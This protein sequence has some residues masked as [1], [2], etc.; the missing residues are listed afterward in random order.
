MKGRQ[1]C[2]DVVMVEQLSQADA[3]QQGQLARWDLENVQT[4]WSSSPTLR[5]L[6]AVLVRL[7]FVDVSLIREDNR[8]RY[9]Q[10]QR[11]TFHLPTS[12]HDLTVT[13]TSIL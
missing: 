7:P 12:H 4:R 2:S 8:V 11:P 6:D 3:P 9:R 10:C 13:S 5:A 1:R